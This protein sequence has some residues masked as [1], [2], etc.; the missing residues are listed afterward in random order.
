M[1]DFEHNT[2]N[3]RGGEGGCKSLEHR[4]PK[5]FAMEPGLK[6]ANSGEM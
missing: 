6:D 1:I 2:S 5:G 4:S 3:N